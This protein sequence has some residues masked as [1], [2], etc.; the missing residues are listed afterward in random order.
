MVDRSGGKGGKIEEERGRVRW[1]ERYIESR[2][3]GG[4]GVGENEGN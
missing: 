1:G 2:G 4:Y 3:L